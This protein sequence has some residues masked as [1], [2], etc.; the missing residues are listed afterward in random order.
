MQHSVLSKDFCYTL[1][2]LFKQIEFFVFLAYFFH[3]FMIYCMINIHC[4]FLSS[5]PPSHLPYPHHLGDVL[6]FQLHPA[7]LLKCIT[8]KT[9]ILRFLNKFFKKADEYQSSNLQAMRKRNIYKIMQNAEEIIFVKNN[10]F[11]MKAKN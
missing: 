5:P 8:F 11:K 9:L 2:C 1:V 10:F 6:P 7:N 3:I 4:P